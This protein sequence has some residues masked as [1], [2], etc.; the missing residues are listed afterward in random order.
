MI[1]PKLILYDRFTMDDATP[2]A[3]GLEITVGEVQPGITG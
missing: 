3:I 2:L 1:T